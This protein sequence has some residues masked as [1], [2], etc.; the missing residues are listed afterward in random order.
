MLR[1]KKDTIGMD[2]N[3]KK[4]KGNGERNVHSC[5]LESARTFVT[6]IKADRNPG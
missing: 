4:V 5:L 6:T 2:S 3:M 1:K